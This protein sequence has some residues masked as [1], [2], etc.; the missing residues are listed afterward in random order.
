M[1]FIAGVRAERA[2]CAT[3]AAAPDA[4]E[5]RANPETEKR[6]RARNSRG[7]CS[8]CRTEAECAH[9]GPG[10]AVEWSHFSARIAA[11]ARAAACGG[12][13]IVS[14]V[15]RFATSAGGCRA[16]TGVACARAAPHPGA[17]PATG[18][19]AFLPAGTPA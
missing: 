5:D 6:S 2:A 19:G 17:A 1:A 18:A 9:F 13:D 11:R 14:T 3:A 8:P 7:A 16:A 15:A 4:T 12:S 10:T